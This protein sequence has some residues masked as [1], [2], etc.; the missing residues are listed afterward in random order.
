[1]IEPDI[2]TCPHGKRTRPEAVQTFGPE[3]AE[4][5]AKAGFAPDPQQELILDLVFAFRPDGSPASFETCIICCRQNLKTGVLKQI[6][7]GWLYVLDEPD[8][9][10]SAHEMTTTLD[11]QSDLADLIL[12]STALSRRVLPQRNRGVYTDNGSERLELRDPRT[13]LEQTVMFKARTKSG[14]RGLARRKLILD[15]AFALTPR[16]QGSLIPIMLA[17]LNP[18]VVYASSPG[19]ADSKGLG[20]IRERGT[21]GSTPMM[22]YVEWNSPRTPCDDPDCLHPKNGDRACALNRVELWE[23]A[24]PTISTGRI[25]IEKIAN[26]RHALPPEEFMREC[27]GW[28]ETDAGEITSTAV[29]LKVWR[30]LIDKVAPPSTRVV[31]VIDVEPD[32]SAASIGVAGNGPDGREMLV[33]QTKAGQAWV[34]DAVKKLKTR[35]GDGVLEVALHPKRTAGLATALTAAGVKYELLHSADYTS[36]CG[37]LLEALD[38]GTVRHGDQSEMT[39]AAAFARTRY[40]NEVLNWDRRDVDLHIGALVAPATALYR[41]RLKTSKPTT[42]PPAPRRTST[43]VH[44]PPAGLAA[45]GLPPLPRGGPPR[46][47]W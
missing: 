38:E 35:L 33:A 19:M 46:P 44:G 40:I 31:V 43:G 47:A 29:D 37:V 11:A 42:P 1:L 23:K 8:V 22:T 17:M 39:T 32:K 15:E 28:W 14:G 5:N 30:R 4:V 45:Q 27:L 26:T 25:T 3:V 18:Q 16:M 12:G 41:Y 10:W 20:E 7:I 13:G 36:G 24:N 21:A 2:W 9:V 34:V 6:V